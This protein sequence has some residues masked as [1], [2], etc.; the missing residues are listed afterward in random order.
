MQ[1][2]SVNAVENSAL[3]NKNSCE[4]ERI[5]G[6]EKSIH[7][8]AQS[9]KCSMRITVYTRMYAHNGRRVLRMCMCV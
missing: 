1:T 3:I 7:D 5:T 8:N 9:N 6:G 4:S 2:M